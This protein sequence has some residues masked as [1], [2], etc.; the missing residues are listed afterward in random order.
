MPSESRT[1]RTRALRDVLPA[2]RQFDDV[3]VE[4]LGLGQDLDVEAEAGHP[5]VGEEVLGDRGP[6]SLEPALGVQERG[7]PHGAEHLVVDP[8]DELTP[9]RSVVLDDALR[10]GSTGHDDVGLA[11]LDLLE[12]GVDVVETA[13]QVGVAEGND[14]TLGGGHAGGDGATLPPVLGQAQHPGDQTVGVTER[15]G[16]FERPVVA[17]VVDEDQFHGGRVEDTAHQA[18]DRPAD[19][20]PL[21]VH[22]DDE[23]A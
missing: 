23:G 9:Q 14:G 10:V 15:L 17:P 8:P 1:G 12:A 22:R 3:E 13:G 2:H 16:R 18:F 11:L 20:D 7:Q 6:E 4:V 5:E 19:A 21:S